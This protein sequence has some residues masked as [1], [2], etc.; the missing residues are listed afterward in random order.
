M[1]TG[2]LVRR[3]SI[4][5]PWIEENPTWKNI[6]L[7]EDAIKFGIIIWTNGDMKHMILWGNG[8]MEK[9]WT[10]HLEVVSETG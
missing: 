7:P 1:K 3:K 5:D 4:W 8:K 9:E 10:T 6:N 2:D